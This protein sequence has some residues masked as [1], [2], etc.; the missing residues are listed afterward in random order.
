MTWSICPSLSYKDNTRIKVSHI[1]SELVVEDDDWWSSAS[2]RLI[3]IDNTLGSTILSENA[4]TDLYPVVVLHYSYDRPNLHPV[5]VSRSLEVRIVVLERVSC[6][7]AEI[8]RA[9]IRIEVLHRVTIA[10]THNVWLKLTF[11]YFYRSF[12]VIQIKNWA[13]VLKQH[14]IINHY[15]SSH[16]HLLLSEI[17]KLCRCHSYWETVSSTCLTCEETWRGDS[18]RVF[19]FQHFICLVSWSINVRI[20]IGICGR[21]INVWERINRLRKRLFKVF[22]LVSDDSSTSIEVLEDDSSHHYMASLFV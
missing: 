3:D 2:S 19:I 9:Q 21:P 5:F 12:E 14:W 15:W 8:N 4:I 6:G 13:R 1:L 10:V 11:R 17:V 20:C 22:P 16:G 7:W 18:F